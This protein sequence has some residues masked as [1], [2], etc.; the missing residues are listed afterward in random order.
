MRVNE[1]FG[2]I[3]GEGI[4]SGELATFVRFVGCNARCKYCDTAYALTANDG[5]EKSIDEILTEVK[6]IG[7]KNITLTGGE[8][9]LQKDIDVLIQELLDA[10]YKVNIETNGSIDIR[11]YND[12]SRITVTM[13]YK[14]KSSGAEHLMRLENLENLQDKDVL[15]FVCYRDDLESVKQILENYDI[16]AYIYLSPVFGEIEPVELVDFLKQC[17]KDGINTDK[18][19]VQ[20]QLH[21]IIWNPDERGV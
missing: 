11:K 19:R 7:Y 18:M 12:D 3:D 5:E 1:I 9:L 10:G 4:K 16:K 15:K 2:S 20:L 6:A 14:T 21:K 17:Y 8:P 13:D